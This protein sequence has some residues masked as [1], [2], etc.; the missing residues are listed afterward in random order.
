MNDEQLK[1]AALDEIAEFYQKNE[2]QPGDFTW[3]DVAERLGKSRETAR[4][5]M[6]KLV[7]QGK[8]QAV[9]LTVSGHMRTVYR[10]AEDKKSVPHSQ[11]SASG[12]NP[13]PEGEGGKQ[14]S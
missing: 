4:Q 12:P 1:K 13:L 7:R 5:I 2:L 14:N 8:Y 10:R 9:R 6:G 11:G 3:E